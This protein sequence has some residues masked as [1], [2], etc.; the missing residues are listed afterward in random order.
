MIADDAD[1][2]GRAAG[3]AAADAGMRH[4]VAQA[5]LQYGEA[6]GHAHCLA[7]AV[8]Q[9]DHAA[10]PFAQGAYPARCQREGEQAKIAHDE[11]AA[12]AVEHLVFRDRADLLP[13]IIRLAPVRVVAVGGN[14]ASALVD[15][16]HR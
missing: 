12:D 14:A 5:R 2:A 11:A 15:A 16:E 13:R 3:A 10:A 7:V 9:R 4:V 8:G 6:L 1:A